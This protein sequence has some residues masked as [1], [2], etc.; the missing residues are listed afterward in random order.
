MQPALSILRHPA[1]GKLHSVYNTTHSTANSSEASATF[2]ALEVNPGD[3]CIILRRWAGNGPAL[4]L[5]HGISGSGFNWEPLIPAL[6]ERFTPVAIDLRGHGASGRPES[7]YL[8]DDYIGDL[9]AAIDALGEDRPL[10]VGHS[11]GGI[12]ALW[13]A[14]KHPDRAAGIVVIDSP[15][16][17]GQDFMPTFDGWLAEN[18]TPLEELAAYYRAKR[19][20]WSEDVAVRRA[21][22]MK[23]TARNV[24]VE[25]RA[26]SLAHD[27]VD[28]LAEIEHVTSP[29]L[30]FQGD[31]EAGSMVN[32]VD[33]TGLADRLPNARVVRKPGAGHSLHQER[34]EEF[35]EEAVPFLIECAA[36]R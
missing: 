15:L 17:S 22:E 18:A 30:F 26:D 36:N 25:L 27:G 19:P 5:I 23:S 4:I 20:E 13:W 11:L 34:P 21:R 32:P 14:A 1:H 6:S 33:A 31:P 35:L 28:R 8:Y 29:I 12:I 3:Q 16:R 9:D 24:F 10:I 2:E 7:G